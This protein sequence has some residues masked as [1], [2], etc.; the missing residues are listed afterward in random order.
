MKRWIV[1]AVAALATAS[2]TAIVAPAAN[3]GIDQSH[4]WANSTGRCYVGSPLHPN[5]TTL[6]EITV[7]GNPGDSFV[8]V[9]IGCGDSKV[10][11]SGGV[12]TGAGSIGNGKRATYT[13]AS[14]PGTGTMLLQSPLGNVAVNVVVTAT[15][16][17]TPVADIHDTIQQVGVPASGDCADVHPSV[18]HF[19]GFPYGGWSKSWAYWINSGKGGPVCTRE[20][21]Y[22]YGLSEWRYVGQQ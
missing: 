20:I 6:R 3:A 2:A 12:L 21:Y 7:T 4:V 5:E 18:G 14:T 1:A 15:P 10:L 13:L 22:D 11:L 16:V 17:T 8:F 19:P 9:N